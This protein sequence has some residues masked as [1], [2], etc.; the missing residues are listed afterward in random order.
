MCEDYSRDQFLSKEGRHTNLAL[1]K[2]GSLFEEEVQAICVRSTCF[3]WH[4]H[5]LRW[6]GKAPI[7][8]IAHLSFAQML[9]I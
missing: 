7:Y 8:I 9:K 2:A 3:P 4:G 1:R 6:Q 5:G